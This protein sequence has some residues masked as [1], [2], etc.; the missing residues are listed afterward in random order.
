[1]TRAPREDLGLE[2]VLF[3]HRDRQGDAR[4]TIRAR[5]IFG[6]PAFATPT[7]KRS[8]A[9]VLERA[10]AGLRRQADHDERASEAGG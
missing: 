8:V 6:A 7:T 5:D 9:S 1:M 2:V 10:A 4:V 3:F